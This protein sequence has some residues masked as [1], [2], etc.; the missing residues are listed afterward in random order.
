MTAGQQPT[1]PGLTTVGPVVILTGNAAQTAAQAVLIA[2]RARRLSGYST[3]HLDTIASALMTASGHTATT[4]ST[5]ADSVDVPDVPPTM[6]VPDAARFLGISKR[7]ARRLAPGLG[8][9]KVGGRWL[10]DPQA[11]TEHQ[12]GQRNG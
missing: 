7:Q 1:V 6:P 3:T 5:I 9:R 8:G 11:V 12:E 2:I 10:L 4:L